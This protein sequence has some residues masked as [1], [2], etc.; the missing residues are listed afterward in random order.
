MLNIY[1]PILR[2]KMDIKN[3]LNI[4]KNIIYIDN[5]TVVVNIA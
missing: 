4:Q 3:Q 1:T 2:K 5:I